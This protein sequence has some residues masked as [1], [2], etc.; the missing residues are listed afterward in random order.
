ME[1]DVKKF[2]NNIL[3]TLFPSNIT[4]MFCGGEIKEE[5][6][7]VCENCLKNLPWVKKFCLRCGTPIESNANYC[8]TCKA[9]ARE[10]DSA[11][12]P[13]VYKDL[14]CEVIHN[15][16]YNGKKYLAQHL[17]LFMAET[18]KKMEK[19]ILKVDMIVPVPL[20]KSKQKERGFNQAELLAREL[21]KI[22]LIDLNINNLKRVKKT[23]TQTK[24]NFSER[25][26]NL[27]D[28]FIV[29]DKTEFKNKVLLLIDDVLTTGSTTNNCAK[30]LKECG[31]KAVYVLTLATTDSDRT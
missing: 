10:F 1:T 28:A 26:E 17:A 29:E 24:L 15:F 14:I 31:A 25:Q 8:I 18:F 12:A 4:C 3:E 5:K 30:L 21:S 11:R 7:A 16:K 23:K 9:G 22:L 20:H 13:F 6:G 2:L 27:K 19:E